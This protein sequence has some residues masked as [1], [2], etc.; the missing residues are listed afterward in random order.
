MQDLIVKQKKYENIAKT[1]ITNLKKD[2]LKDIIVKI[3]FLH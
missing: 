2:K 3:K 1:I